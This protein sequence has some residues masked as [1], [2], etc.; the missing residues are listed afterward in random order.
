MPHFAATTI[1]CKVNQYETQ[2]VL[3]LLAR[4][5]ADGS[6]ARANVQI[7][8]TCCVT[9]AAAAKSRGA[10]R[11]AVRRQPDADL[12]ILGCAATS[13]A[14]ALRDAARRA[15][16]TGRIL[17]VGHRD[18]VAERVRRLVAG[19]DPGDDAASVSLN[20]ERRA[21][22]EVGPGRTPGELARGG[23]TPLRQAASVS[24]ASVQVG[25]PCNTERSSNHIQPFVDA[26]VK[27][28]VGTSG[29]PAI[30][31]FAGH[32]RAF[33]KVQDGCDAACTYCV[34]SRLRSAVWSRPADD[35]A[36]EVARLVAA[37]HREIV[38]CG[39]SLG[40]YGQTTAVRKRWTGPSALPE[41]LARVAATAGLWRVRL[42]SIEPGDVTEAL[43]EICRN[44][45]AIAPHLHIPLQSGSPAVLKRMNRQY[46]PDD[47]LRAVDRL[48][49]AFDRPA[50]TTDILV[51]FPGETDEDFAATMDLAA[52]S[53]FSRIHIFPFS[54]RRGTPAWSWRGETP[55]D[56]VVKD[57][58]HRLAELASRLAD[59]CRRSF[60][61]ET[62]EVLTEAPYRRTPRGC[63]RGLTD[64]YL[65]VT[66]PDANLSP[67]RIVPVRVE[68]VTPDG[69]RGVRADS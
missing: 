26:G 57:R 7:V 4:A 16:C 15:G 8:N 20:S 50:I 19:L 63:S 12:L 24:G 27:G 22:V 9:S 40:A 46:A 68:A 23:E 13:S 17:V 42:S 25:I 44:L 3:V 53:A 34:V 48:R 10:I 18:D 2:A 67:G 51:G 45:P 41:L 14:Q 54:P 36:E 65:D 66:F 31:H 11:Q 61:G 38:L 33:V 30:D 49:G 28:N 39:I 56:E 52:R 47:F 35:V 21:E 32:Q 1:G 37:G 62:V 43:I 5:A 6:A 64:R 59:A 58:C 60:L 55:P 29:L 69:L